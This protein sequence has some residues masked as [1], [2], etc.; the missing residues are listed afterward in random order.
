MS[1]EQPTKLV[2]FFRAERKEEMVKAIG[3]GSFAVGII[4]GILFFFQGD[5][6]WGNV[7]LLGLGMLVIT[8]IRRLVIAHSPNQ[9]SKEI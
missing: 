8:L 6:L 9:P 5:V 3:W 2:L 1:H 7:M 4:G